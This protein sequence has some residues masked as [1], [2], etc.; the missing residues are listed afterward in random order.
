MCECHDPVTFSHAQGECL[1]TAV[2]R[3]GY[4]GALGCM[5]DCREQHTVPEEVIEAERATRHLV[6]AGQL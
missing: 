6:T 5:P 4:S 3:A 2:P 1:A